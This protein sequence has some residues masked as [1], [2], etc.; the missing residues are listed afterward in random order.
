[1]CIV[2]MKEEQCYSGRII[3]E[4]VEEIWSWDDFN[5]LHGLRLLLQID[6]LVLDE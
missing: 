1:M 4:S 6:I 3:I 5:I 2:E